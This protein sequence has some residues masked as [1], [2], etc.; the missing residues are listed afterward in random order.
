MRW[1]AKY[2]KADYPQHATRML[3]IFAFLPVYIEGDFIWLETYEVLQAYIITEVELEINV[4]EEYKKQFF[5]TGKW[6]SI[7]KRVIE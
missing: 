7:S 2:T 6:V 5:A 3:R 4:R 1:K